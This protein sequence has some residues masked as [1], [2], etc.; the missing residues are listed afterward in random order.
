M[1]RL[2]SVVHRRGD[3]IWGSFVR[4]SE[5]DGWIKAI[6]PGDRDHAIGR[7]EFGMRNVD[8]AVG[9]ARRGADQ[10]VSAELEARAAA[11]AALADRIQEGAEDIADRITRETGKARWEAV[12]EVHAAVRAARRLAAKGPAMLAVRTLREGAAYAAPRGHGVVAVIT[13]W[14]QPL[15][16]PVLYCGA[17][18]LAGN[19]VVFKPSKFAPGTG[20]AV[21]EAMD[22]IKL[23]R[24]AFNMVQGP[25]ASIGTRLAGHPGIDAIAFAGRT[26][27]ADA[28]RAVNRHRPALPMHVQTGGKAAAIVL[29]DAD[30]ALA[31]FEITVG[32]FATAGQRHDSTARV[33]VLRSRF[34]EL[35]RALV[36]RVRQLSIGYGFDHGVFMGPMISETHR[37]AFRQEID[38]AQAAGAMPLLEG[39]LHEV[40]GFRG[41]YVRPDVRWFDAD[42]DPSHAPVGPS[43]QL[44]AVENQ[45]EAVERVGQ[46]AYRGVVSVFSRNAPTA[47]NLASR[48]PFGSVHV[49]RTT[50]GGSLRLGGVPRGLS[51]NGW[52]T[53]LEIVHFFG[54]PQAV[55]VDHRPFDQTRQVPGMGVIGPDL[56]DTVDD[57]TVDST[58]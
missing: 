30:P 57:M 6:D 35:S 46:L 11:L 18:L 1:N 22:R 45:E 3:Y 49:N 14:T 42:P 50:V 23:P 20:Q 53:A 36:D 41:F 33:Y 52:S 32:A 38:R 43:L 34:D 39:G 54:P 56:S 40:D 58:G 4:S 25:G 48:L 26:E 21:A 44:Y 17:A 28:L 24:G 27:T 5:L 51:G 13:P 9:A 8:D 2:R 12:G 55:L 15:L 16:L 47:R 19:A 7:Y 37:R 29:G 31:A 10:M